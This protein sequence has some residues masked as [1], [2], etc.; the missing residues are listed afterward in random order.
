MKL[1]WLGQF[2]FES[3]NVTHFIYLNSMEINRTQNVV[4]GIFTFLP[5]VFFPVIFFQIFGF[6][7]NIVATSEHSDPEPADILLGI[8]SFLVPIILVSLLSLALLIFYIVHAATNKKLESIEQLMW[9][10]LFVFFGIIAFPIYW[11]MRIWNTSKN[12]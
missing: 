8:S 4:L 6:V 5:F 2:F 12:P 3:F 1:P 7:V 9:I 11:M 10:L